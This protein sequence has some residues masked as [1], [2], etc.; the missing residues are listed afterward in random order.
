MPLGKL[1]T[2]QPYIDR[3]N[4]QRGDT[5]FAQSK[6]T[7]LSGQSLS[8]E[9]DMGGFVVAQFVIP[10]SF[11]GTNLTFQTSLHGNADYQDLWYNGFE[12]ALTVVAGQ[13][14]VM[15][16]DLALALFP[17]IKI[18]SGTAAAPS[19]VASDTEIEILGILP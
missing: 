4:P 2:W 18:R 6:A 3:R 19:S 15:P 14:Y 16:P 17:F 8:Q 9:I 12:L 10:S 7:I 11:P 13:N 1:T 5:P